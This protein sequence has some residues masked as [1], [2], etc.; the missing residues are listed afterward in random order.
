MVYAHVELF[1]GM[2]L[3]VNLEGPA[4]VE[5]PLTTVVIDP[6]ARAVRKESGSLVITP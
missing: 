5:S 3:N 6:G 4:I 1:D 2:K